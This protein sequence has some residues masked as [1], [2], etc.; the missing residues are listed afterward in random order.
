MSGLWRKNFTQGI[1]EDLT[2]KV[3]LSKRERPEGSEKVGLEDI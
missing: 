1:R 3:N 2:E